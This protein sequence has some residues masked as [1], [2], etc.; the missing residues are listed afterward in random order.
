MI[1][2]IA[3]V[4]SSL[5]ALNDGIATLKESKGNLS[6]IV[7]KWADASE[8]VQNVEKKKTGVM[9]YKESLD[10][11]SAKRQL[12]NFDRQLKD[13]CLIQ[14]QAD[15]YTSIKARMAESA[16]SHAKEVTRLRKVRKERKEL[17]KFLGTL[18]FAVVC[19]WGLAGGA[20]MIYMKSGG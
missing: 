13:I 15:L 2:E 9:S 3:L 14:G 20:L 18:V 11:E 5:K 8:K 17:F 10:L 16:L 7:G 6:D 4:L 1:G 19:F 12:I